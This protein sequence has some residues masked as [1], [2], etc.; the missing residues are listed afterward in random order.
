M[1]NMIGLFLLGRGV[2][3]SDGRRFCENCGTQIGETTNFCPSCGAA[4]RPDPAVP[5][6]PPP[7]RPDAG[8]I[9]TPEPGNVPPVPPPPEKKKMSRKTF[10]ITVLSTI[11]VIVL[12]A[13]AGDGG[14]GSSA[15]GEGP[16]AGQSFTSENYAELATDPSSFKGAS[17]DVTGRVLRNAD[18]RGDT[19]TFQ[20]FADPENSD[21]N[22][23]VHAKEAPEGITA[24]DTVRVTGTVRGERQG[25]NAMGGTVR[26]TEVDADSVEVVEESR[27]KSR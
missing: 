20:M 13:N 2:M 18:V 4:Q 6:G 24:G 25:E 21:W 26:S 14:G 1:L 11:I 9:G 7:Q 8:R 10:W 12:I 5:T 27:T 16:G 19:T 15:N 23:L 17:V 22:T 3:A